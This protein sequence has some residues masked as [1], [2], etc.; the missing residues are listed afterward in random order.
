ME[1]NGEIPVSC[2]AAEESASATLV[3]TLFK[4]DGT[5]V[6]MTCTPHDTELEKD[7]PS[8]FKGRILCPDPSVICAKRVA[9]NVSAVPGVGK[10]TDNASSVMEGT[11]T[12]TSPSSTLQVKLGGASRRASLYFEKAILPT[13]MTAAVLIL[14]P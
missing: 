8:G 7:A 10:G 12:S 9:P 5:S 13:V 11:E 4:S 6:E 1:A 14:T 3:I 2:C